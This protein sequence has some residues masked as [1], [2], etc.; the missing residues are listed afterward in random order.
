M[1]QG[2]KLRESI[3][4]A[5]ITTEGFAKKMGISRNHLH[6]IT[7]SSDVDPKHLIKAAKILGIKVEVFSGKEEESALQKSLAE[8]D[9]TIKLL[10]DHI[11][12]LKQT[13]SLLK[14]QK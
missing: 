6:L 7:R 9:E 5:G 14:S 8:K 1:H 3:K 11:E 12:T 13:I 2:K 10:K 4:N